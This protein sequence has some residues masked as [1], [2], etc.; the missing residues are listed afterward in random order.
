V[1]SIDELQVIGE[2]QVQPIQRC[3]DMREQTRADDIATKARLRID[4]T[5][6]SPTCAYNRRR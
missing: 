5:S 6:L 2:L 4:A 1:Q 3:A